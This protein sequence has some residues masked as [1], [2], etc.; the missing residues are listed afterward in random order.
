SWDI[1]FFWVAR[2]AMLGLKFMGDV[3]FHHVCINSLVGD[4]EGK[5]MS[6]SKG[7][8]VD[9]LDIMVHT[10][11]DGLRFTMAAIENHSR[12]VAFTPDRLESSRNFMNKIWNAARFALM[13]L[14]GY[15]APA[16]RPQPDF[17]DQWILSRLE[18]TV[19]AV[20]RSLEGYRFGEAALTL[21]DFVWKDFCD[22][23]VELLKLRLYGEAAGKQQAQ[24]YL[25]RVLEEILRL[26]HPFVPFI[27]EEIWAQLPGKRD[28]LMKSAWPVSEPGRRQP[29][30][31]SDLEVLRD[32]IYAVRNIRGEMNVPPAQQVTLIIRPLGE[33]HGGAVKRHAQVL[34]NL[35][36]LSDLI[37]DAGAQKPKLS[38]MAVVAGMELLMPLEGLIDLDKERG[39]LEKEIAN[40]EKAVERLEAKLQ[41][42]FVNKAP[43]PVVEAERAK[44]A[45]YRQKLEQ[46]KTNLNKFS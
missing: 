12:Y 43:A 25:L 16:G 5:K 19:A 33:E 40:L 45:D 22:W 29:E 42:D 38:A 28:F 18:A 14:E 41:G 44:L 8:T 7:N 23:Y 3:P 34:R 39:R 13:N 4:A 20:D 17:A 36:K 27:T 10:G 24:Y 46:L 15:A 11:A 37:V 26:L 30:V 31:E 6:K 1:I 21:Y 9:P 32:I 35:L 2:M